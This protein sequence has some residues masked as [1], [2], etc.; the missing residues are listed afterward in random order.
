[1]AILKEK[2]L[3]SMDL[4]IL[5]LIEITIDAEPFQKWYKKSILLSDFMD[6][7]FRYQKTNEQQ[8]EL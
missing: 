4:L 1:M 3:F 8:Q 6:A 7:L 5:S 2:I